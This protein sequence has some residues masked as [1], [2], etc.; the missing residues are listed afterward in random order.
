MF[1]W[2]EKKSF[3]ESLLSS[4]TKH[5]FS[6]HVIVCVFSNENSP[7]I[8]KYLPENSTA[9]FNSKKTTKNLT[10]LRNFVLPL[11]ASNFHLNE[12]KKI[13]F[14]GNEEFLRKEWETINNFPNVYIMPVSI[15]Y[16]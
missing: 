14:V 5:E 7:L 8:G 12:L 10:G 3:Q 6:N 16:I 2:S 9:Y 1:H 11:R 15:E 4:N 13:I